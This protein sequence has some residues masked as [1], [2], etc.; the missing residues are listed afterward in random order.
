ML[1]EV[2][3]ML[4]FILVLFVFKTILI[5]FRQKNSDYDWFIDTTTNLKDTYE[6]RAEVLQ[7]YRNQ[8][9]FFHF[10]DSRITERLLCESLELYFRLYIMKKTTRDCLMPDFY[11]WIINCRK[12]IEKYNNNSRR[13]FTMCSKNETHEIILSIDFLECDD[14]D[15]D[16]LSAFC[17]FIPIK[18]V[19][20]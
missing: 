8:L 11:G 18:S 10:F 2:G 15:D 7:K 20:K 4:A 14:D 9:P 6:L 12:E 13:F 3:I 1:I 16:C 17:C 19:F 5:L